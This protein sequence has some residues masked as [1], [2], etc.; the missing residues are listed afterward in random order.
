[1]GDLGYRLRIDSKE[2]IPTAYVAWRAGRLAIDSRAPYKVY[3][4]GLRCTII[5][6]I[7]R[8]VR[9]IASLKYTDDPLCR[10]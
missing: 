6:K 7:L 9:K 8:V 4:F 2:S 5:K 10:F 1:L 3:K